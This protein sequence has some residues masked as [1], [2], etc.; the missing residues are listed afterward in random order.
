V[1]NGKKRL[2]RGLEA[3]LS[4]EDVKV[5]TDKSV[6]DKLEDDKTISDQL[7]KDTVITKPEVETV[8]EI[9]TI[10]KLE[11]DKSKGRAET[12]E[13]VIIETIISDKL[14]IDN[15]T[16]LKALEEGR[17]NPRVV[18]WSPKS[19][20]AL[21]ILKKTIP[22]FSISYEAS[23]LLESAIKEKYPEIWKIVEDIMKE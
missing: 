20:V 1:L 3:L 7:E 5:I 11:G 21:R 14:R 10:N 8:E 9:M 4:G 17:K 2:G 16:I 13:S 23:K 6:S 22:E 15:N 12:N 18:V 19:S